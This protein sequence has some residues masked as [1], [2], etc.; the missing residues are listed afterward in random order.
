MLII[1]ELEQKSAISLVST[2][3]RNSTMNRQTLQ[4]CAS[5]G[6]SIPSSG[7]LRDARPGS[8]LLR[9]WQALSAWLRGLRER[10]ERE[11]DIEKS[12]A[13]LRGLSDGQLRDMGIGR[14]DIARV[15]RHGLDGR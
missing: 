7:N 3:W 14:D 11:G 4:N 9:P 1:S 15:V 6:I 2:N 13:H 10:W 5:P 8:G 12:I